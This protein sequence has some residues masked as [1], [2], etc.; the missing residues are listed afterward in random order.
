MT[1]QCNKFYNINHLVNA[2]ATEMADDSKWINWS[3]RQL[4]KGLP[5]RKLNKIA[6]LIT[7]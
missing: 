2:N 1:T 4:K 7:Q 5:K 6:D 3:L